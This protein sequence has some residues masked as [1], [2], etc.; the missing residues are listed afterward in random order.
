MTEIKVDTIVNLAGTGK[1]NFPVSPTVGSNA[2]LSTLNTYSYTSS[3]TAPEGSIK[4]G[5]LWW[6]SANSKSYVYINNQWK[7]VDLGSPF[8]TSDQNYGDKASRAGF[9][10]QQLN[11]IHTFDITTL[12]NASDW[13]DLTR[14]STARAAAASSGTHGF[15]FGGNTD[16]SNTG[17]GV[18]NVDYYAFANNT[19][20]SDFGDLSVAAS[21]GSACS[22]S[23]RACVQL[24]FRYLSGTSTEVDTIDY[25]TMSTPGN[26]TDFGDTTHARRPIGNVQVSNNTRGLF[27]AGYSSTYTDG[28]N[29]IDYITIATTGNATDFG[30]LTASGYG[31][32]GCGSGSGDRGLF[33]GGYPSARYRMI[34]Y[35]TISTTGNATD[36]GDMFSGGYGSHN[37]YLGSCNNATRAVFSGSHTSDRMEYVTMSTTGNAADFGDQVNTTNNRY[38]AM[39]SGNP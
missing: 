31:L 1:P 18:N 4:N 32:T 8:L 28:S 21:Q 13:K 12:G 9:G 7:E 16:G 38:Q 29:I 3:G 36:F 14:T 5:A 20:G 6:D 30:D 10:E 27:A 33:G 26:A 22:D 35:V 24:G 15:L 23:S 34:E 39:T 37:Y 19:N 25:F 17:T 2:A 11:S